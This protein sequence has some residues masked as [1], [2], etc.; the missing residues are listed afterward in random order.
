MC[1][2]KVNIKGLILNSLELN[3]RTLGAAVPS[4]FE[5]QRVLL[6]EPLKATRIYKSRVANHSLELEMNL[7]RLA[8]L[9]DSCNGWKYVGAALVIQFY[10][11]I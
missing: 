1:F 8:F 7:Q 4:T 10:I 3:F 5:T 2:L 6:L 11:C 9:F